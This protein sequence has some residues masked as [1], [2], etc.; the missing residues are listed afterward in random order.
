MDI[1]MS[2]GISPPLAGLVLAGFC[3]IVDSAE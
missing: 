1:N 3:E 2:S